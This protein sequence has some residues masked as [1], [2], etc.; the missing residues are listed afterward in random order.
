MDLDET[1]TYDFILL[2]AT[3][4]CLFSDDENQT[5]RL[6]EKVSRLLKPEG[7]FMLTCGFIRMEQE[8]N[9]LLCR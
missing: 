4:I 8:R 7:R 1:K 2:P 3:T 6:L 5:V 9:F